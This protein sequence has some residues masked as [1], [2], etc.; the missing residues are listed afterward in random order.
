MEQIF[1]KAPKKIKADP[2]KVTL[3]TAAR[4]MEDSG[5]EPFVLFPINE[6]K[7]KYERQPLR[8]FLMDCMFFVER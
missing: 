1:P 5:E 6:A 4:L 3:L 7:T 8:E 2:Q